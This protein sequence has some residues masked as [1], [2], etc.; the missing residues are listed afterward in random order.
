MESL[1]REVAYVAYHLH[2]ELDV[3][4]EM[5]H[6]ERAIWVREIAAIN[7]QINKASER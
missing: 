5:E 4:L 6:R 3:I 2:W 7:E 1:Y